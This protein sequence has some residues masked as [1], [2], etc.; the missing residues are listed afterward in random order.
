MKRNYE[1]L[2]SDIVCI[3]GV[4]SKTANLLKKKNVN[5]I[6]DLLWNLPRD[7][8]DRSLSSKINEFK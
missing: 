2:L 6:F 7:F 1:Y 3:K 4:G 5:T 8:T